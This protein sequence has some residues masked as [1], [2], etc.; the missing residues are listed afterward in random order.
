MAATLDFA[1][2]TNL[3]ALVAYAE[4]N[5]RQGLTIFAIGNILGTSVFPIPVGVFFCM[6]AGLLYG[7]VLGAA[8]YIVTCATGAW[9]TFLLVRCLRPR[10]ITSMGKYAKTW[11]KLDA[12]ITREGVIICMLWRIAPIAPFVLSSVMIA[13]T[14]LTQWQYVWTTSIGIIPSTVPIVSAAALGRNL[15]VENEVDPMQI[16]FNVVSIGAG[17]YV[18]VR[19]AFIASEVLKRSGLDED[20]DA[21]A[22]SGTPMRQLDANQQRID[23]LRV[24]YGDLKNLLV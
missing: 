14:G 18:C 12:A 1:T 10:I 9:F 7:A 6:L 5:P 8:V 20:A 19:L 15:L 11:E 2:L 4:E 17:I 3:T 16:A 23:R 21:D 13:M 22:A 24:K